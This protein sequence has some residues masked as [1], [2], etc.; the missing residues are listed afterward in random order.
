M[1]IQRRTMSMSPR[2]DDL[3]PKKATVQR[4]FKNN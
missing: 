4:I 1:A 3:S 2:R